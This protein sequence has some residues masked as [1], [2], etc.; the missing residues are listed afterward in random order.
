MNLQLMEQIVRHVLSNLLVIPSDFINP[1]HTKSLMNKDFL[2]EQKLTFES[3]GVE[4]KNS[5]WGCQ[6][7]ADQQEIKILL[8]DCTQDQ[9]PSEFCL[10]VQMKNAPAYGLYLINCSDT[11]ESE[12][13]IACTMN[14]KDW[15]RCGTYL[16]AT[17]LAGME[18]IKDI[19]L[20]WNKCINY[21]DQYQLMLSFIK[22]HHIF[23]EAEYE[24]QES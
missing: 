1:D 4:R 7:S 9:G 15:M 10:L 21:K 11:F 12:P 6:L 23:Y 8:G 18:Q 17:F 5:I 24:G 19:G 2:L 3:D 14:N 13:L 20:A 16:Q 22:Y